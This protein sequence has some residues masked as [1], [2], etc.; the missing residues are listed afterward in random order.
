MNNGNPQKTSPNTITIYQNEQD[1]NKGAFVQV[2][3]FWVDDFF[4]AKCVR[5]GIVNKNGSDRKA[6]RLPAS[7]WKYTLH[8]WRHVTFPRNGQFRTDIAIDQF[9][10]RPDAA[11][12]WTAAFA[13]SGVM[14]VE[15]GS[16][17]RQH[18]DST[19]FT[20]NP[21]TSHAAWRCFLSALDLAY[22]QLQDYKRLE[23]RQIGSN[24]GAWKVVVALAVDEQ[25]KGAGLPPAN[26]AFLK[27]AVAKKDAQ[28]R[29]IAE[30]DAS[31]NV[32]PVFWPTTRR[33]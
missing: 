21:T 15:L 9:P 33:Q 1:P 30:L 3:R 4:G 26:E 11:V 12:M 28:G 23:S 25:R 19:V 17:T 7:F 16:W 22:N 2:P 6:N 8:L 29:A 27:D 32:Q 31:G 5:K 18:N 14:E 10:V 13:V 24:V 20:Y